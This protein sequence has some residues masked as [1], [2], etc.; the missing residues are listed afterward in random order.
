LRAVSR[1]REEGIAAST[2]RSQER[3]AQ[4]R[5]RRPRA[6]GRRRQ[7]IPYRTNDLQRRDLLNGIV[8]GAIFSGWI[9]TW[10]TPIRQEVP[11][12]LWLAGGAGLPWLG[13]AVGRRFAG[14]LESY[15]ESRADRAR[16]YPWLW[17]ALVPTA[18]PAAVAL[19][20]GGAIPVVQ[21]FFKAP[22]FSNDGVAGTS[23]AA[24]LSASASA[25]LGRAFVSSATGPWGKLAGTAVACVSGGVAGGL[26]AVFLSA[27]RLSQVIESGR[28]DTLLGIAIAGA[29]GGAAAGAAGS[30]REVV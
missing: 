24:G 2:R 12:P 17:R 30:F 26:L 7:A 22:V 21:L 20:A 28:Y 4:V 15:L 14:P 10:L 27:Y 25:A 16:S 5:P 11:W 6:A 1:A 23:I 29:L 3:A 18:V 13:G 8:S 19:G 9:G